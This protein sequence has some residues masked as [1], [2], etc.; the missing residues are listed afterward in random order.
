MARVT[1]GYLSSYPYPYSRKPVGVGY[2]FSCGS[3][4]GPYTSTGIPWHGGYYD[5]C[6]TCRHNLSNINY[7]MLSHP[8]ASSSSSVTSGSTMTG[9]CLRGGLVCVCAG[10]RTSWVC[11]RWGRA[12]GGDSAAGENESAHMHESNIMSTRSA[13]YVAFVHGMEAQVVTAW[14][15]FGLQ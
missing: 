11:A 12:G 9:E 2:G 13:H 5:F 1:P 14:Q 7:S 4:T 8:S 6:A 3:H 10:A 15:R